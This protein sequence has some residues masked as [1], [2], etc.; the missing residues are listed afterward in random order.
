MNNILVIAPHADDE[1]LGCGAT[2]VK[3]IANGDNVYVL[4]MTNAHIGA[5]EL[6]S[7]D[8]I[9]TV[10][11]EAQKAHA[12]L[13]IKE[14]VF[15]DF[16]APKLDQQPS[17][18]MSIE[19]SKVIQKFQIDT[20]YI[21][22]RGDIHKDHKMV[23]DAVLVA[24]RPRNNYTVKKVLAYET[25]SETECGNPVA[26]DMFIP[27]YFEEVNELYFEKKLK[28]LSF[29]HSQ[30]ALFPA[31]RSLEAVDAL[32]KYRGATISKMRAEAFMVVR[33]IS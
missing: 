15:L 24:V 5:P 19:I 16:P 33:I 6:F 3:K 7:E 25:L 2:I 9:N 22:H 23:F 17:Y 4:V 10:R 31:S 26:S 11:T 30:M 8:N 18:L 21:P 27:T 1:L 20:V 29:F 28:A 13:G 12:F 14:T 32:S